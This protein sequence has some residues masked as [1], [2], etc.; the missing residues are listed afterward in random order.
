VVPGVDDGPALTIE[1]RS[2]TWLA[3]P[4][5]GAQVRCNG[6]PLLGGRDLKQDDVL[7]VGEAQIIVAE[8]ARTLLRLTVCHLVGNAT[9]APAGELAAVPLAEVSDE[10]LEI[11]PLEA[12][13][14]VGTGRG[15]AQTAQLARLQGHALAIAIAAV[16]LLAT[17]VT[18]GSMLRRVPIDV[19]PRDAHLHTPGSWLAIRSGKDLLLL[20]GKHILSAERAGYVGARTELTVRDST[21]TVRLYLAKLPGRLHIDTAGIAASVSVDGVAAGHAPGTLDVPAGH[22]TIALRA[23]RYLDFV[24]DIEIQGARVS[25]KLSAL[26]HSSWGS[27]KISSVSTGAQVRVD[28]IERG[29]A[30]VT[31]SA[32][33]GVREIQIHAPGRQSWQSSVVLKAGETLS[34]GPVALGEPDARLMV[35]SEPTGAEVTVAGTHWGRTP[36]QID[37]P[38]GVAHQVTLTLPGY[39]SWSQ[40]VFADPGRKLALM[41][42]LEPLW[43]TLRVRGVPEGAE[44][45]VDGVSRGRTPQSVRLPAV[46]HRIEVRQSGFLP[47]EGNLGAAAGLERTLEYHLMAAARLKEMLERSPTLTSAIGYVLRLVPPGTFQ[48]GSAP[49]EPGHRPN[50]TSRRITLGRPFYLGVTEVTNGEFRQFQPQH[51]SGAISGR[52][53][54]HDNEPVTRVTWEEAAGFCNWLSQREGLPDA[55]ELLADH[56]VLRR[57]LSIG[58]RLP[59]EAEWEYSARYAAP[60]K[61]YR[62]TWGDTLPVPEQAGNLAGSETGHM[63]PKALPGYRDP[64]PVLAPVGQFRPTALGLHDMT[65][66]AAEWVNDYYAAQL[67]AMPGSDPLGPEE[68][69]QHVVRGASWQSASTEELL[70]AR[71]AAADG[72]AP[73]IGFRIARYVD[74]TD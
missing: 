44:L 30:P 42:H 19:T 48:M 49:G 61:F 40:A 69:T 46:D 5:P 26:L 2:G 9:V 28:G 12:R 3:E 71:R 17:A 24:T 57:P 41:A 51:T 7:T 36:A 25:Q 8:L 72:P 1:R 18:L 32:P 63:L 47:F 6:R 11:A 16:L 37:L 38:A 73:T 43:V 64:Y 34:V 54:D 21:P 29:P 53:I 23:E 15:W 35:T 4:A 39:V 56:H 27:L 52:S 10:D 59:S 50:E 33:S 31:V 70:L 66:N 62:Y 14:S 55:Y 13:I 68:G 22:H 60:G 65:G 45:L 74:L 20:P 67:E 58:Y